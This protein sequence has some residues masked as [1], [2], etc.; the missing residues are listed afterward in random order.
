MGIGRKTGS[1]GGIQR[2]LLTAKPEDVLEGKLAGV[3]TQNT[4]AAGTLKAEGNATV[5]VV[6]VG[7]TF[8]STNFKS[9]QQGKA[10]IVRAKVVTPKTSDQ[11][12]VAAGSFVKEDV[13]VP[14]FTKPPANVIKKGYSLKIYD[15]TIVGSFEGY[16]VTAADLYNKGN[17][18]GGIA[19]GTY[20][21]LTL[22]T[23]QA[24]F[25]TTEVGSTGRYAVIISAKGKKY[26]LSGYTKINI[27]LRPAYTGDCEF[28]FYASDSVVADWN[29]SSQ[30]AT[31]S[32][33]IVAN[34]EVT[35]SIP[36]TFS[37]T[38]Y[39]AV[40][41]RRNAFSQGSVYRLWLS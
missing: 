3:A 37:A 6:P 30:I 1:G 20:G 36:F 14:G 25:V 5:E 28:V 9:R 26:N 40:M 10:P 12:A 29:N 13:K 23:G 16:V 34:S 22:E 11:V 24:D 15:E 19:A 2:A 27:T 41:I 4:P 38:K 21:T 8:Y 17:N 39:I 31:V 7:Y 35:V 32:Q 18:P 33:D